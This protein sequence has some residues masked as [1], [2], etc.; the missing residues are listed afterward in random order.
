LGAALARV[1]AI[2]I[3]APVDV[4]PFDRTNVDG[5][6]VQAQ[7]T[8]GAAEERPRELAINDKEVT[9]GCIPTTT[10]QPGNAASIATTGS[11]GFS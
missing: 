9:T 6:A 11:G 2:D 5:F 10:L 1:L 7:G 3:A 4:L 8:F